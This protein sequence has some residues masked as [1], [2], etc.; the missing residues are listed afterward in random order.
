MTKQE[1]SY[2]YQIAE[3]KID[4]DF[5]YVRERL[6]KKNLN[7]FR[8]KVNDVYE[9]QIVSLNEFAESGYLDYDILS[10]RNSLICNILCTL[11]SFE[12]KGYGGSINQFLEYLDLP[13]N[14]YNRAKLKDALMLLRDNEYVLYD[15][16]NTDISV[17]LT[18]KVQKQLEFKVAFIEYCKK[19]A[20]EY[21]VKSYVSVFKVLIAL[22]V[23]YD[24][25]GEE[26]NIT[27]TEMSHLIGM[28]VAAIR[29]VFN[30]ISKE[31]FVHLGKLE[32]EVNEQSGRIKCYGRKINVNEFAIN[33][34]VKV[35]KKIV[36]KEGE[37]SNLQEKKVEGEKGKIKIIGKA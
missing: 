3:D 12:Q 9:Y 15:I 23:L 19:V 26:T 22:Y 13:A 29:E 4:R 16:S 7:I 25:Y 34:P 1:L 21:G 5:N 27:Y 24:E 17:G 32:Y 35:L 18:T 28:G 14:Q 31:G 37:K 8:T 11:S 6:R 20:K 36:W 30:K 10:E 33:R 2:E